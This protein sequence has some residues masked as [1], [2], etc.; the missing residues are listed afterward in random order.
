MTITDGLEVRSPLTAAGLRAL[1]VV[2]YKLAGY[3]AD[4]AGAP[5][6]KAM[7]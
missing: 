2:D 7:P 4:P 1:A 3:C 5:H 6:E